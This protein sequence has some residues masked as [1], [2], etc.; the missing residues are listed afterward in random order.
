MLEPNGYLHVIGQDIL[1]GSSCQ[2]NTCVNFLMK[3][4]G[5]SLLQAW[6][7]CS[8]IP[9]AS[10][11]LKLPEIKVGEEASFVIVNEQNN[12]AVI[13]RTVIMGTEYPFAEN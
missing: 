6:R 2:Q 8:L 12:E 4:L 7:Q 5:F 9:A 13:D 1:A 10:V 3:H 11:G